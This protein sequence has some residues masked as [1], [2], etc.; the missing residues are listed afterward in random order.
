V[1][2]INASTGA[3]IGTIKGP[4]FG[5]S[6]PSAIS[7]RGRN[8]WVTSSAFRSSV[9]ELVNA[10]GALV[11]VIGGP[12]LALSYAEAITS[13]GRHLGRERRKQP[14]RLGH[15]DLLGS[16]RTSMGDQGLALWIQPP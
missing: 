1:T 3:L 15:R 12:K 4:S 13:D 10:T 14:V 5:F 2:E 8:V 6:Y 11:R 7:I 16:R 9:T